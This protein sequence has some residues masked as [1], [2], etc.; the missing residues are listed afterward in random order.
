L[1]KAVGKNNGRLTKILVGGVTLL[2]G[3]TL[4]C[5]FGV[6]TGMQKLSSLASPLG[7]ELRGLERLRMQLR[8]RGAVD[9][10]SF[11]G[12]AVDAERERLARTIRLND[13]FS[14][15]CW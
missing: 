14:S 6:Q 15:H 3:L 9:D 5:A 7:E 1:L 12:D 11:T 10:G 13:P 2:T 4:G 8:K